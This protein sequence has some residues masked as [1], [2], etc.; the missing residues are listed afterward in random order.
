[1]KTTVVPAQVTTVEDKI[2]GNLTF[3]Q[4]MLLIIPLIVGTIIYAIT[5]PSMHL[6]TLK[7]ILVVFQFCLFGSLA[8][9]FKGKILMD[10]LVIVLKY[11]MR[12][13]VYIFTKNDLTGR[14]VPVIKA[15]D[16]K[17]RTAK[18]SSDKNKKVAQEVD[19][20]ISNKSIL[21][22]SKVSISVKLS[23]K[24]GLDVSLKK[25]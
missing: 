16:F 7:L 21:D 23:K 25:V 6:S 9:R 19:V 8:I 13:R 20:N 22:D 10:W 24:G 2:A 5:P 14:D 1:M 4:I 17:N 12:P 15:T 11:A 3:I 18:K